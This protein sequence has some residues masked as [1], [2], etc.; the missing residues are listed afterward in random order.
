MKKRPKKNDA[1]Y[2]RLKGWVPGTILNVK[3][4]DGHV[5]AR[6]CWEKITITAIGEEAILIRRVYSRPESG[7]D[8]Q[9]PEHKWVRRLVNREV[10]TLAP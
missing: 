10:E 5:H 4:D 1:N 2:C 9:G 7:K 8:G 6:E 3:L